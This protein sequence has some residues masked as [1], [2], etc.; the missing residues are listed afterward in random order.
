MAHLG[1]AWD[2]GKGDARE[3]WTLE[4]TGSVGKRRGAPTGGKDGTQGS[5]T[6]AGGWDGS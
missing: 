4:R 5:L 1:R 2:G 6:A 3:R